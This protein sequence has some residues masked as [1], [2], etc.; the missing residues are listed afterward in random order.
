MDVISSF[1]P[2]TGEYVYTDSTKSPDAPGH[3]TLV[4]TRWEPK[5]DE[6]IMSGADFRGYGFAFLTR[7]RTFISVEAGRV[8]ERSWIDVTGY[9]CL[10]EYE[11][12]GLKVLVRYHAD[13]CEM[14][15]EELVKWFEEAGVKDWG[16]GASVTDE[17]TEAAKEDHK[18]PGLQQPVDSDEF[19]LLDVFKT[20]HIAETKVEELP[21]G[22]ENRQPA[23]PP[24]VN[25]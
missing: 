18:E 1:S 16:E 10:V 6:I 9:H 22:M 14:E 3:K 20:L 15:K 12:F 5:N 11:F 25:C 13:G 21:P 24:R 4:L 2:E 17:S 19:E 8:I 23:K 7:T